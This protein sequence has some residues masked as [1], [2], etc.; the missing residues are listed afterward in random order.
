MSV[1]MNE[2]FLSISTETRSTA[3]RY[4]A[5][6]RVPCRLPAP[7]A[8]IRGIQEEPRRNWTNAA[9]S[10]ITVATRRRVGSA[11]GRAL[12][13]HAKAPAEAGA[14]VVTS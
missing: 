4:A 2:G 13:G 14:F 9:R 1:G 12:F 6:R 8:A 5:K 3:F 11:S 7:R 10:P